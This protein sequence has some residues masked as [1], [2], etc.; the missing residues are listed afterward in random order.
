MTCSW[1]VRTSTPPL[2]STYL[3]PLPPVPPRSPLTYTQT[4]TH[5]WLTLMFSGNALFWVSPTASKAI[6]AMIEEKPRMARIFL[7][8]NVFT[9]DSKTKSRKKNTNK[10][11]KTLIFLPFLSSLV[12]ATWRYQRQIKNQS[13]LSMRHLQSNWEIIQEQKDLFVLWQRPRLS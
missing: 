8:Q 3:N 1:A 13:F 6:T 7:E 9:L 12:M 4:H 2:C 10:K 11:S 5:I